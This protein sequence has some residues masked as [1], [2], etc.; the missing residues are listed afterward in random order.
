MDVPPEEHAWDTRTVVYLADWRATDEVRKNEEDAAGKNPI[1]NSTPVQPNFP[2][3]QHNTSPEQVLKA[4]ENF[5]FPH[6]SIPAPH[7]ECEFRMAVVL[8]PQSASVAVGDGFK[9]WTTFSEGIWSGY[10]GH[11]IVLNGGQDSQDTVYKNTVATHVEAT[12]RLKTD[13]EPPAYIECKTRGYRTAPPEIMAALQDPK[14]S[15]QV[16]PR[17]CQYR[18]FISMK[19]SDERYAEKLNTAMWI[20]SCLWKGLEVVY[21]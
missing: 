16:D 9:K 8:N 7:L 3:A 18:V 20:G 2:T 10:F 5:P 6:I 1:I 19:T 14:T 13:D 17:L 4:K 11:G 21:E 12:H 15:E